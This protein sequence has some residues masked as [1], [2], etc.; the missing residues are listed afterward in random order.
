MSNA[1][2]F[3]LHTKAK[4]A[5]GTVI[6]IVI[7]IFYLGIDSTAVEVESI[8]VQKGEFIINVVTLGELIAHESRFIVAPSNVRGQLQVVEL[9]D[10]GTNVKKGDFLI[11]FDTAELE[12][13]MLDREDQLKD[14]ELQRDELLANQKADIVQKEAQLQVQRYSHEQAKIRYELMKFEP[15][16]KQ[17][18]QEIDMKKADL[19]LMEAQEEIKRLKLKNTNDLR[20]LDEKIKR[21]QDE[22]DEIKEQ[23]DESTITAPIDGLVVLKVNPMANGEKIKV[24]QNLHRRMQLIELPDLSIMK[25]E[26]TVNEVDIG[27]IRRNQEV[28]ITLDANDKTYY[29]T[30]TDIARLARTEGGAGNVKV[31]D[32]EVTIKNSDEALKPGMS[33]TCQ[34]ITDRLEDAVFIPLQS[35]FEEEGETFVYLEKDY[36]K[37]PVV[38]GKRNTDFIVIT[39][40]LDQGQIITL[41]NPFYKLESI[42]TEIREKPT[43]SSA[44]GARPDESAMREFRSR[45]MGMGRFRR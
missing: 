34:V 15:E 31:F 39:E 19:Q 41:R 26:T 13:R 23:I 21:K 25:V 5:A 36:S 4:Y 28:I 40:G 33:A 32:V 12:N 8:E 1:L 30:I 7:F 10:E 18:Q 9:I 14:L 16:I 43:V 38:T 45:M 24:G 22:I 17:R 37:A 6:L 29:G 20:R 27:K 44:S 3:L 2:N 42:G 35:V 11:R